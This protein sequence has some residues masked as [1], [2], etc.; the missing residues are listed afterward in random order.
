VI[1]VLRKTPAPHP[2]RRRFL[3]TAATAAVTAP[4]ALAGFAVVRRNDLVFREVDVRLPSIP[5]DLD[6]LR[7]VQLS[8]IH[9][10]PFVSESLLARAIGMANEA[11]ADL[12]FVTGDL[13]TMGGDPLD[14]CLKHLADL[15]CEIA[16]FGCMGNH[17]IYARSQD[18]TEKAGERIGIKFLR[19]QSVRLQFGD[20]PVV[21]TGVDYQ[22]RNEQYLRGMERLVVPG[23]FNV[24]L[25]HNPD[26]FPVAAEKKFDLTLAGHT[27]GGQVN[28]EMIHPSLNVAKFTTPYTYGL[29]ENNGR[30]IYVTRGIGTI[31]VPARLGA[32]P[33]V[34]LIRLCAISS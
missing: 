28:F 18:Y 8:D 32:P 27:H 22:R 19:Q 33:E 24:L 1:A 7:L 17:E 16:A 25:S 6:G 2:G 20:T 14:T 23:A 12:A 3:T 5:P 31:G 15:R 21:I 30:S 11:R 26:V 29:Y 9:L 4:A 34:A 13:I 10:S